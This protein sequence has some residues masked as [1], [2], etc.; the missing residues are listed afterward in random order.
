MMGGYL[1]GVCFVI[2][3]SLSLLFSAS[4]QESVLVAIPGYLHLYFYLDL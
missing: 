2:V 4:R 3:C 1:C